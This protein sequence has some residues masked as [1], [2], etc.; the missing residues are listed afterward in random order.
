MG[1][2]LDLMKTLNVFVYHV[3]GGTKTMLEKNV[4]VSFFL[5]RSMAH[6][7]TLTYIGHHL[8]KNGHDRCPL[9]GQRSLGCCVMHAIIPLF[10]RRHRKWRDQGAINDGSDFVH[11]QITKNNSIHLPVI[12]IATYTYRVSKLTQQCSYQALHGRQI[13][14]SQEILQWWLSLTDHGSGLEVGARWWAIPTNMW[15]KNDI[16]FEKFI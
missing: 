15:T 8:H 6:V 13:W 7:V 1:W 14:S 3:K 2:N 11:W 16:L 12:S 4:M 5:Y 9:D 10:W